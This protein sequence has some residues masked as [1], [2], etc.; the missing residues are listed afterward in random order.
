MGR[1]ETYAQAQGIEDTNIGGAYVG[2]FTYFAPLML[3]LAIGLFRLYPFLA[4]RWLGFA[5]VM[6]ATF[7]IAAALSGFGATTIMVFLTIVFLTLYA[8][9]KTLG[10]RAYYLTISAALFLAFEI[11]RQSLLALG[12]QGAAADAFGKFTRL[13]TILFSSGQPDAIGSTLDTAT[14]S[15]WSLLLTSLET[16]MRNPIVGNGFFG[17]GDLSVGGHSFLVDTAAIFG[18]VGLVPILMFFGLIVLGL[19][20]VRVAG[21]VSWPVT[22]S[23]IL[24]LVLF[25][26]LVMNPYFL[27]LLSLSYFIFLLLGFA[28]AD[29][30]AA[31][32]ARQ[33]TTS[34][35]RTGATPSLA[36]SPV[37]VLQ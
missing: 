35:A 24:V 4:K 34:R 19:R 22:S 10:L 25:A 37:S 36:V 13:F 7:V 5:L 29:A 8:P 1:A 26:G 11:L 9:V 6:Q 18:V 21:K 15:R 31:R 23:T 12:K 16:F 2:A 28:L 14:S 33:G 30:E 20:R 17:V 32:G 27:S 3:F